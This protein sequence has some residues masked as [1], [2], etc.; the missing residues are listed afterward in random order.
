MRDPEDHIN[1][2]PS[3]KENKEGKAF[4]ENRRCNESKTADNE[5]R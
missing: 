4:P 1:N 3:V 5:L 2:Q